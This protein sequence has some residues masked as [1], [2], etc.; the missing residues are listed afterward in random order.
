[1]LDFFRN[2]NEQLAILADGNNPDANQLL[3]HADVDLIR[4]HL[5]RD[6]RICAYATGRSVG[7]GR[8]IWVVTTHSLLVA[9]TGNR[10]GVS[11]RQTPRKAATATP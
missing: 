8:T 9:Q 3:R 7:N 5:N 10:P 1:M 2:F 6:E 4:N 11:N